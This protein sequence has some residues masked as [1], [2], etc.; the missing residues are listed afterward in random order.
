[1]LIHGLAYIGTVQ[2]IRKSAYNARPGLRKIHQHTD[3]DDVYAYGS[4]DDNFER[5]KFY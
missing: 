4:W 5:V 2:D 3:I 1:M